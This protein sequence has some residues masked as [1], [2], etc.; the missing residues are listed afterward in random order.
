MYNKNVKEVI[1]IKEYS[2]IFHQEYEI[3]DTVRIIN[4]KQAGLYI[5]NNIPL[6]DIFW[7]R[8]NLVFVFDKKASKN[9]K[10]IKS[11]CHYCF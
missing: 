2:D 9:V 6:I 8:D 1:F 5:K 10:G 7:S 11:R 4:T 3:E